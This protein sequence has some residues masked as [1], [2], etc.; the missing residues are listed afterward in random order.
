MIVGGLLSPELTAEDLEKKTFFGVGFGTGKQRLPID[1]LPI[2]LL[3]YFIPDYTLFIVDEFL[4]MNQKCQEQICSEKNEDIE[5]GIE[6]LLDTLDSFRKLYQFFPEIL[7]SSKLMQTAQ[8]PS[9]FDQVKRNLEKKGLESAAAR[10]VP[11]HRKAAA[12]DY[13]THEFSCVQ[14]LAEQGFEQKIGPTSEK[15]Y[16]E[17]MQA[18]EIPITFR[19]MLDSFALATPHTDR[20]VPYIPGS[21]GP[22]NGQR[23][24]VD[25]NIKR[26]KGVLYGSCPDALRYMARIASASGILLGQ[27]FLAK[28]ELDA[29]TGRKLTK[30]T[31]GMVIENIYNP[32]MEGRTC[33][34]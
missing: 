6:R 26:V 33:K 27:R 3:G 13:P 23:L 22:N 20:V 4:R 8:Y 17:I 29:L 11:E 21:R 14:H 28:E 18:L 19:Y 34:D 1:L 10:I 32:L 15:A 16:D 9:V 2:Y 24:Y 12:R 25:D 30:E 7:Y 31:V 5:E